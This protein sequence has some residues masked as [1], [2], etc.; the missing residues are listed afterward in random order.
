MSDFSQFILHR[1]LQCVLDAVYLL[2]ILFKR[3]LQKSNEAK[4][5]LKFYL[6][7]CYTVFQTAE[8]ITGI[9]FIRHYCIVYTLYSTY[10][11]VLY[12]TIQVFILYTLVHTLLFTLHIPYPTLHN[13]YPTVLYT[14]NT[15]QPILHTTQCTPNTPSSTPHPHPKV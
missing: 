1:D 6:Q 4:F 11:Y 15:P 7:N 9:H 10:W 13:P 5:F 8:C 14:P 12:I 2:V 3:F